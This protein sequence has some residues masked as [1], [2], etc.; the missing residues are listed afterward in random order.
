MEEILSEINSPN[1]LIK[2][3]NSFTEIK[4]NVEFKKGIFNRIFI[5][6]DGDKFFITDNKNTLRFM[7]TMYQLNAKDVKDCINDI[8]HHY[9]FSIVKGEIVGPITK[10]NA[11]K[12]FNEFLI[13]TTTL[14][15]MFIFFDNP[16]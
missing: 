1:N 8:V 16:N 9:Q 13:C 10:S 4:T 3:D 5:K 14:A 15:N 2:V 7:N 12:R 6:K 11:K